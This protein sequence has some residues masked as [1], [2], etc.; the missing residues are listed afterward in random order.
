MS[1][2]SSTLAQDEVSAAQESKLVLQAKE[3]EFNALL[4][5][6]DIVR[7]WREAYVEKRG[8]ECKMAVNTS[9]IRDWVKSP[10]FLRLEPYCPNYGK[11]FGWWGREGCP[12]SLKELAD[13]LDKGGCFNATGG[14]G[15]I[16]PIICED[17][18]MKV[19]KDEEVEPVYR[20]L[21]TLKEKNL[22]SDKLNTVL[23]PVCGFIEVNHVDSQG[24]PVL[25]DSGKPKASH[26]SISPNLGIKKAE[27]EAAKKANRSVG[28]FDMK[29]NWDYGKRRSAE[30]DF[31]LK[32][33]NF[34]DRFPRSMDIHG[35]QPDHGVPITELVIRL[36]DVG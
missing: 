14:V 1:T 6:D 29:G 28:R 35:F 20:L 27:R 32:D 23:L 26:F 11:L 19:A 25:D 10:D 12:G 5:E 8:G 17:Y 18:V 13:S 30:T 9:D 34:K 7:K 31:T 33:R 24:N 36:Q 4:E 3:K 2:R 16:P 15:G 22:P 21:Y